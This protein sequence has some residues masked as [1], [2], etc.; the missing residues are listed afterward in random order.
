MKLHITY[1]RSRDTTVVPDMGL[2]YSD[3]FCRIFSNYG[4]FLKQI[5]EQCNDIQ[6]QN[7]FA[8]INAKNSMTFY[9]QIKY[10]WDKESYIDKCTRKE[11]IGIIW[12]KAGIWKLKGIR[13][14][15]EKVR[16]P[17]VLGGGM[18]QNTYY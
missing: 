17:Y 9:S 5:R 6:G 15:L 18:M 2:K 4:V 1:A 16:C 7:M 12:L 13:R 3:L 10:E 11:R 8:D 14:G